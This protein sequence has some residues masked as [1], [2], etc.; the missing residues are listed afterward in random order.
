MNRVNRTALLALPIPGAAALIP[1]AILL[2]LVGCGPV[3]STS[4]ISSAEGSLER[5]R[6]H[7]AEEYS[8]YEYYRAQHYLY[9]AKE[10]WGYSNFETARNYAREARRA[11]DAAISNSQEAPWRGHPI[12]GFERWSEEFEQLK[13]EMEQ[14]EERDELEEL[15]ELDV[16]N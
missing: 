3:Q 1:L 9:K 11:A 13:Q 5:A 10:E 15:D 2:V 8:P 6:V 12:Y 14:A 4:G 7:D 16:P